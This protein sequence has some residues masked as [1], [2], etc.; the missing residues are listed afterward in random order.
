MTDRSEVAAE[1]RLLDL[2]LDGALIESGL[3]PRPG[4]LIALSFTPGPD[5]GELTVFGRVAHVIKRGFAVRGFAVEFV[6]I[7]EAERQ[8]LARAA[9]ADVAA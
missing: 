2:S 5:E 3:A 9:R 8:R 6:G 1:L 4:A 7:D